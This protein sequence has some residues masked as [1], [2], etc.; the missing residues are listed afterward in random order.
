MKKQIKKW[1]KRVLYAVYKYVFLHLPIQKK[2]IVFVS[3]LG[4][5][6]TGSP[7]AIYEEMVRLGLDKTYECMYVIQDLHTKVGKNTI[8]F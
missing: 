4:R 7:R 2:R 5:N 1:L 6:Y 8:S 3:S